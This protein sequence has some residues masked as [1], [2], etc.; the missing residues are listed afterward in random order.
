MIDP[1]EV[2]VVQ[3]HGEL[4]AATSSRVTDTLARA[5]EGGVTA[6]KVDLGDVSFIDSTVITDLLLASRNAGEQGV[7]FGIDR[8]TLQ[9]AVSRT[10]EV[11]GIG[12]SLDFPA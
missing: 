10:L 7:T 11:A 8:Q 12:T 2:T 1:D 9:P 3:L 6:V 5:V 4:D